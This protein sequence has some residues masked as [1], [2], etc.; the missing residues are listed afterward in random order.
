[1]RELRQKTWEFFQKISHVSHIISDI[2][3][4]APTFFK[5]ASDF[6]KNS[7]FC[8]VPSFAAFLPFCPSFS[9]FSRLAALKY[10]RMFIK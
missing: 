10:K 7:L 6:T 2:F 8:A 4:F 1:M 5:I 3:S 9:I